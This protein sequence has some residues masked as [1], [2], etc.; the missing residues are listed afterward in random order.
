M[1]AN[2]TQLAFCLFLSFFF[3]L[4]KNAEK[5]MPHGDAKIGTCADIRSTAATLDDTMALATA[6]TA[7]WC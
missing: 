4:K 7:S 2:G 1:F 3:T 5:K 6:A